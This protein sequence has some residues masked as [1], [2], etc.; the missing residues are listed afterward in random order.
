MLLRF[1]QS[2]RG[3]L[4]F[5]T[6]EQLEA[7][8]DAAPAGTSAELVSSAGI[9]GAWRKLASGVL[10]CFEIYLQYLAAGA[11]REGTDIVT[12]GSA[13]IDW[14]TPG[15]S[16]GL[17]ISSAGSVS[18]PCMGE[19]DGQPSWSMRMRAHWTIDTPTNGQ[20]A[21][22]GSYSATAGTILTGG[23]IRH[24]NGVWYVGIA[25]GAPT[26]PTPV[27][28]ASAAY[29]IEQPTS[30]DAVHAAGAVK[31][32]SANGS[33]WGD[34][35]KSDGVEGGTKDRCWVGAVSGAGMHDQSDHVP[36]IAFSDAG[37]SATSLRVESL[38]RAA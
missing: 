8:L 11:L 31:Q 30:G 22:C 5:Q 26:S 18:L 33:Y 3:P 37:D 19:I 21:L 27:V 16:G 35:V 24:T 10:Y 20:R 7:F 17:L 15:A 1:P 28:T 6:F 25:N 29:Q 14:A 9:A 4:R 32:G 12:H 34:W 36:L 2:R 23:A 13:S 38:R